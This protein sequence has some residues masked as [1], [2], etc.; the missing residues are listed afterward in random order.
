MGSRSPERPERRGGHDDRD[1]ERR[2]C[3]DRIGNHPWA[4]AFSVKIQP[5]GSDT[6]VAVLAGTSSEPVTVEVRAV[7]RLG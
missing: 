7:S 6:Y 1:Q 2:G 5:K 3:F 4:G